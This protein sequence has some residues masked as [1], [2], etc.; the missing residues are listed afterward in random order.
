MKFKI[1]LLKNTNKRNYLIEITDEVTVWC[2]EKRYQEI[3]D[4]KEELSKKYLFK[5]TSFP[6]KKLRDSYTEK[7]LKDRIEGFT[8]FFGLISQNTFM[9][10]SSIFKNF[11][12]SNIYL[13]T[14][15]NIREADQLRDSFSKSKELEV[16]IISLLDDCNF[17]EDEI[18]SLSSK[19]SIL[20]KNI[21]EIQ[22]KNIENLNLF[23]QAKDLKL[24]STRE[25]N[26]SIEH[27]K[28]LDALYLQLKKQVVMVKILKSNTV[29]RLNN[30]RDRTIELET[31][32]IAI[33]VLVDKISDP[34]LTNRYH[35]DTYQQINKLYLEK[36]KTQLENI[37]P[38]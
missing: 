6:K 20:T 2:I 27:I 23:H 15:E 25:K 18:T 12:R 35:I 29:E 24:Q 38:V 11:I 1:S 9:L 13:E 3:Y 32:L 8:T 4:L 34:V 36:I 10:T 21:K 31:E 26:K 37:S 5:F 16:K 30:L 19:N 7:T 22:G 14:Y 17:L 28:D 33:N